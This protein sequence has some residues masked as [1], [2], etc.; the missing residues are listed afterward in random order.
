MNIKTENNFDLREVQSIISLMKYLVIVMKGVLSFLREGDLAFID[1]L[2]VSVQ[3]N[4]WQIQ[5]KIFVEFISESMKECF[6]TILH[7]KQSS[8][9]RNLYFKIFSSIIFIKDA[10]NTICTPLYSKLFILSFQCKFSHFM[11]KCCCYSCE[12]YQNYPDNQFKKEKK[13][14]RRKK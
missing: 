11:K 12:Y 5:F 13:K 4:A 14:N 7:S 8:F 3:H 9:F 2:S 10:L 1:I 6:V